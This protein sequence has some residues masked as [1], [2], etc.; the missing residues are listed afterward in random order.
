MCRNCS[1]YHQA[2]YIGI[3]HKTGSIDCNRN[4]AIEHCRCQLTTLDHMDRRHPD[5]KPER[6]TFDLSGNHYNLTPAA[7]EITGAP[8]PHGLGLYF[9][10]PSIAVGYGK[11]TVAEPFSSSLYPVNGLG[12][13]LLCWVKLFSTTTELYSI[14]N[15]NTGGGAGPFSFT[16]VSGVPT[17]SYNNSSGL[18][19]TSTDAGASLTT[20]KWYQFVYSIN[21][22]GS[23]NF[24]Y[25]NYTAGLNLSSGFS[26]WNPGGLNNAVQIA[27]NSKYANSAYAGAAQCYYDHLITW[28]RQL[29]KSEISRLYA[30]PFEMF[31]PPRK[32]HGYLVPINLLG[33]TREAQHAKATASIHTHFAGSI[34]EAQKTTGI[35]KGL[36]RG[37][38]LE[39]QK[40]TG[41]LKGLLHGASREAQKT[42]AALKALLHGSAHEA[43]KSTASLKSILHGASR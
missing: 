18:V 39:A 29:T 13:T 12:F 41:A 31:L 36:L 16:I 26:G 28:N 5:N 1:H 21:A 43:Q 37:L 19:T 3:V 38:S 25:N 14:G 17:F 6:F 22:G 34:H 32:R 15:L 9:T 33:N 8:T 35:L 30:Q 10:T 27:V 11:N 4:D 20:G 2:L 40:A 24:Y 7:G 23:W 42:T